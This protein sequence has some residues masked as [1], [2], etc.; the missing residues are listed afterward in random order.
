MCKYSIMENESVFI[1]DINDIVI[2]VKN[3]NFEYT[4][5]DLLS[6]KIYIEKIYDLL[7]SIDEFK[8]KN[9]YYFIYLKL[10][11]INKN[12]NEIKLLDKNNNY[13]TGTKFNN[14]IS[15]YIKKE[16][17]CIILINLIILYFFPKKI[18]FNI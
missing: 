7:K 1:I 15:N 14:M 9:L 17:D 11:N 12:Y 2:N 10:I 13:L 6:E 4:F 18:L 5:L 8:L 16:F 3:H